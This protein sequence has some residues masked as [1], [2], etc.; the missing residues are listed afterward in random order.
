[1]AVGDPVGWSYNNNKWTIT[2][3]QD[4]GHAHQSILQG[5]TAIQT[6][7]SCVSHEIDQFT[8]YEDV[9][10]SNCKFCGHRITFNSFPGGALSLRTRYL[11]EQFIMEGETSADT[12]EKLLKLKQLL[13]LEIDELDVVRDRIETIQEGIMRELD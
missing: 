10:T 13:E 3:P 8:V 11:L 9:I 1:M 5:D 2:N 4:F 6:W 12:L 7:P